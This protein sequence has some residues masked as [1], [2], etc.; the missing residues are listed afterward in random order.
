MGQFLHDGN[1]HARAPGLRT[2]A[3]AARGEPWRPRRPATRRVALTLVELLITVAVLGILAAVLIPYL[4][5]DLPERLESAAQVV[6]S[7]LDYARALA[8]TNNSKYRITF[9]PGQN[10]YYLRHSGTSAA[11]N[12]LPPSPF[13]SNADTTEQQTT[14]LAFLPIPDPPVRLVTVLRM[15]SGGTATTE[16][17]FTPLGGTTSIYE[18]VVWLACGRGST[19][20]YISIHVNPITGLTE[21]GP[22]VSELPSNVTAAITAAAESS[23]S[24]SSG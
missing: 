5:G 18:S 7:D 17:E 20:R 21:V 19:Q 23:G 14:D 2:A 16:V 13:R 15:Q 24:G 12:K 1:R 6:E 22:V 3:P 9:E 10:R 4:S 8:V 11:L